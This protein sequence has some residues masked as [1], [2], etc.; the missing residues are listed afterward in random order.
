MWR[1]TSG[2]TVAFAFGS[3]DADM[4]EAAAYD[5]FGLGR[6]GPKYLVL[7]RRVMFGLH[8][9][10]L[11]RAIMA[12]NYCSHNGDNAYRPNW[13]SEDNRTAVRKHFTW[14]ID[15]AVELLD[16]TSDEEGFERGTF[17]SCIYWLI[18]APS[19]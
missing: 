9:T 7:L 12:L 18:V 19:Q 1:S 11:D 4:Q 14:T 17:A 3:D 16:R 8:P 13:M 10:A 5:C 15:E 2:P 6:A